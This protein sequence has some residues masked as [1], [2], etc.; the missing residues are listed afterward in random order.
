MEELSPYKF[1]NLVIRSVNLFMSDKMEIDNRTIE[2]LAHCCVFNYEGGDLTVIK[3]LNKYLFSK[4]FLK[5]ETSNQA[6]VHKTK[7]AKKRWIIGGRGVFDLGG[8]DYKGKPLHYELIIKSNG[9]DG[10]ES[11]TTENR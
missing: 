4:G 1:F 6:S 3:D 2:F 10:R 8:F 7:L 5:S 9:T 11:V